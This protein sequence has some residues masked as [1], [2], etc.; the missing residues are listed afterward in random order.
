MEEVRNLVLNVLG[1]TETI[2]NR[3]FENVYI[4]TAIKVFLGL[5]AAFAAPQLPPSLVNLF[6]NI[7]VRV[8]VAF[9]IVLLATRDPSMALMVAVAFVMTL[10]TANKLRLINTSLSVSD[11]GES[12]WLPSAREEQSG[13]EEQEQQQATLPHHAN[14]YADDQ[15]L[16]QGTQPS[17]NFT[18]VGEEPAAHEPADFTQNAFTSASQ[19]LDAQN[20][21]VPGSN[22]ESCVQTFANQHCPQGLQ[23]NA[24]DGY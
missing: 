1:Q 24:P 5:Y 19:F 12:S 15:M 21:E 2:L 8:G 4:S 20:N 18:N 22:Q 9:V 3:G 16:M 13:E 14:G 6:D 17:E 23:T 10:Q 7:L 11:A